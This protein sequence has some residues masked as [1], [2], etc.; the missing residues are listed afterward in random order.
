M[1]L[2]SVNPTSFTYTGGT[3]TLTSKLVKIYNED[4]TSKET[5]VSQPEYTDITSA[6]GFTGVYKNSGETT[7][8]KFSFT[9]NKPVIP[10]I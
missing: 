3:A 10:N 7:S 8:N 4:W 1:F 2:F 6:T 5:S 9:G